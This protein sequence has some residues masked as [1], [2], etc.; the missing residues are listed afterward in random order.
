MAAEIDLEL[1][2]AEAMGTRPKKGVTSDQIREA[3]QALGIKYRKFFDA[4]RD[5]RF[6]V[7]ENRKLLDVNQAGVEIFGYESRE[8]MLGL[9][10][11]GILY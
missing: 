1:L 9:D 3:F 5:M 10:S 8:E 2:E 6:V 11:V 7:G 4:S